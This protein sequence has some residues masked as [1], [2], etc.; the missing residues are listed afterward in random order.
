MKRLAQFP[1]SLTNKVWAAYK[2]SWTKL[3]EENFVKYFEENWIDANAGWMVSKIA[4]GIKT[5]Q[6]DIEN[7]LQHQVKG[8]VITALRRD[9][10]RASLH[11]CSKS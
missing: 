8:P 4:C 6:N 11:H 5:H 1:P 2:T 10:P 9:Q 7:I 3:G